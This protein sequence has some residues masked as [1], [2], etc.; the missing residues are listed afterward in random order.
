MYSS[1]LFFSMLCVVSYLRKAPRDTYG[2]SYSVYS[3]GV[4]VPFTGLKVFMV[5]T[6]K[7]DMTFGFKSF[8]NVNTINVT[9]GFKN[10]V[11]RLGITKSQT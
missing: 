6:F 2:Q 3:D 5:G 7:I 4:K 10:S 9:Q 8:K 1:N 11:T